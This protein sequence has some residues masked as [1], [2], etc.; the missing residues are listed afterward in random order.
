M[1]RSAISDQVRVRY[2]DRG[3]VETFT[4]RDDPLAIGRRLL[5]AKWDKHGAFFADIR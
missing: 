2:D 4:L 3:Y 5:R 1:W